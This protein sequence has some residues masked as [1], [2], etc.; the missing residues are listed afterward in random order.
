MTRT[1]SADFVYADDLPLTDRTKTIGETG[2]VLSEDLSEQLEYFVDWRLIPNVNQ[3]EV[4]RF[5]INPSLKGA[6]RIYLVFTWVFCIYLPY[7]KL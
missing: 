6:F 1:K 5:H 3:T 4:W 2:S 7:Y